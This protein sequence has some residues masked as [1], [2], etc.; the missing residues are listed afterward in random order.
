MHVDDLSD[1]CL[2]L[3]RNYSDTPHINVGT[4]EDITIREVAEMVRDVAYPDG[5]IVFDSS[6]PDGM[7]RKLLDVQRLH[8]VGWRHRI[9]LRKGLE[10]SYTWF[11]EHYDEAIARGRTRN[12]S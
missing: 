2:F 8:D 12:D 10:D 4:G 6:K 5:H 9:D 7:A 3:M 11:V 1:C